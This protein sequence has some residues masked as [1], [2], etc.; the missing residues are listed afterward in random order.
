MKKIQ[1]ITL[2]LLSL[3]LLTSCWKEEVSEEQK[4]D[5]LIETKNISDFWNKYVIEKVWTVWSMQN[6]SISSQ[7]NW[8]V[9]NVY[10]KEGQY[11]NKWET[12]LTIS[13]NIANYWLSLAS[14]K[15]N[16]EKAKLSYESTEVSL[17]KAI[18]DIKRDLNNSEIDNLWSNSSLELEKIENSIKKIWLDFDNLKIAN[19]EQINWFKN[20]FNRDVTNFAIFTEDIIDFSDELLWVTDKNKDENDDFEDY[21][22]RK[23]TQQLNDTKQILRDLITYNESQL[24]GLNYNFEWTLQFSN[25]VETISKWYILIDQLLVELDEVM[26]NSI[27]SIWNLSDTDLTAFKSQISGFNTIYN[28][29]NSSFV[30]LQN[31]LNSFLETY[32]NSEESLLKQIELL[33]QDKRI[34]VQS[35]DYK[36]DVSNATLEEAIKNKE[37]N[38]KNLDIVITDAEIWYKQALK[39]YNKLTITAPISWTVS[40]ILVDVWQEIN[41]G[42]QLLNIT[43]NSQAEVDISLNNTDLNY[44]RN[45]ANAEVFIGEKLVKWYVSSVSKT[46]NSSLGYSATV[47]LDENV[48]LVWNIVKVSIPVELGNIIIPVRFIETLGWWKAQIKT[49]S[50]SNLENQ[51]VDLWKIWGNNIEILPGY[52]EN[53][54]LIISEMKNYDPNKFNLKLNTIESE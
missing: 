23:D 15:N 26:D 37:L 21:L 27:T 28:W 30:T 5:F 14:A 41:V 24:K 47:S 43:N 20:S 49:L 7:V 3:T 4:K 34:Y 16:L 44:I 2:L 17:N 8:R 6:I 45:W 31:S 13:D 33:E 36:I 12:I 52:D 22:W 32:Q 11:V 39:Q 50:G 1:L 42:L 10:I 54:N 53:I 51:I 38:L 25:H 46:A 19:Q 48:E 29:N 35:L 40:D 18:A 9:N